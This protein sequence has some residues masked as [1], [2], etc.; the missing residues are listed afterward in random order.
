MTGIYK[1][2]SP[3]GKVYVGQ[4]IDIEKRWARY[5]LPN[6][7][8][9][10]VRL[11]RS[12]TKYSAIAHIFEVLEECEEVNLNVRERYWQ[13]FYDVL[14]PNGLNCKLTQ[15]QDRNG[16]LS[17]GTKRRISETKKGRLF[18]EEHKKSMSE[19]RKGKSLSE[20]T[21]K[22]M[23]EAH[24]G[25]KKKP[26]SEEH[27]RKISEVQKGKSLSEKHKKQISEALKGRK[28]EPL[29]EEHKRKISE[30]HK[31][32]KRKPFS[33]EHRKNISEA[34]K[35]YFKSKKLH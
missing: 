14:S 33:E 9:Q 13:D 23:S 22:K 26:F 12:F 3:T 1:I 31:G 17:E 29:S 28:R 16:R 20:D 32:I 21:K 2:T 19:V 11:F 4:A 27:K 10:Q 18:S 8:V 24:K 5:L 25:R 15:T 30:V 7:C 6:N 34:R 35:L